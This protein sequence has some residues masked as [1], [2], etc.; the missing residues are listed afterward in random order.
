MAEKSLERQKRG[1]KDN[2]SGEKCTLVFKLAETGPACIRKVLLERGWREYQADNDYDEEVPPW[3]LH[4]RSSRFKPSEYTGAT[5]EQR[6]NHFPKSTVITRKDSLLRQLRKMRAVYGSVFNFF[7]D[8]FILPSEYTKFIEDYSQQEKKAIWICKPSDSSRGRKIFLMKD[9]TD[10]V[11]D[12]Q[13]IIQQYVGNPLTIGGYKLDLRLYVL[14]TS[15]HPMQVY[16][17]RDGLVR[18]G[19]QKYDAN[20]DGDLKN[21]FS[22][23]TNSSINKYSPTLG[24]NKDVVGAG[25]K[26]DFKQFRAWYESCGFDYETLWAKIENLVNLTL[27]LLPSLVP[28]SG[29]CFELY[30]FDVI[31][32]SAL[33]PWLLEVNCSPALGQECATDDAVK[34]PLIRDLIDVLDFKSIL[35]SAETKNDGGTKVTRGGGGG[36]R[37][38][39]LREKK[40][41]G[42]KSRQLLNTNSQSNANAARETTALSE[43]LSTTPNTPPS[44]LFDG[45]KVT[46]IDGDVP[47]PAPAPRQ[48]KSKSLSTDTDSAGFGCVGIMRDDSAPTPTA[49]LKPVPLA[50]KSKITKNLTSRTMAGGTACGPGAAAVQQLKKNKHKREIFHAGGR[51]R[52]RQLIR[53]DASKSNQLLGQSG[54][55]CSGKLSD[56][57]WNPEPRS[58]VG[59]FNLIF[60]FSQ[61]TAKLSKLMSNVDPKKQPMVIQECIKGIIAEIRQRHR[62]RNS[63]SSKKA[64]LSTVAPVPTPTLVACGNET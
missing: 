14:V 15:F 6:L 47:P 9:L 53:D 29:S 24:E 45:S 51:S 8:G 32:D 43:K 5:Q 2:D 26:W 57:A 52:Q 49:A 22:H 48:T 64:P 38:R 60:P 30:G 31:V 27:V 59:N 20:P 62:N 37:S 54:N 46:I 55:S 44:E 13:Y 21:M 34:V 19:T 40:D 12:Q 17:F 16:L 11:Y 61:G 33:K 18:F 42:P 28:K 10:L 7:P 50:S 36:G 35:Q 4:W 63:S 39:I 1:D 41:R 56:S 23:L 25:C 58:Q 3:H